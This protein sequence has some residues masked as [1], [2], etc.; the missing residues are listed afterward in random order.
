MRSFRE[1][2]DRICG[3]GQRKAVLEHFKSSFAAAAGVACYASSNARWASSDLDTKMDEA[4]ENAPLFIE[5][6]Y[7]ACQELHAQRPLT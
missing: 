7:N 4:S 3:Q 1:L 2:I 5:A 6:F